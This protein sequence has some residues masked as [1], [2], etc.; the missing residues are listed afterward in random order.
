MTS[1][2]VLKNI[3][4][5]DVDCDAVQDKT[6]YKC[7]HNG[8]DQVTVPKKSPKTTC[9]TENYAGLYALHFTTNNLYEKLD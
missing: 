4:I 2:S 7:G 9:K 6:I 1:L 3:W 8:W 5:D